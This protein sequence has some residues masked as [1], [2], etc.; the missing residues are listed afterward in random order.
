MKLPQFHPTHGYDDTAY[1]NLRSVFRN[2]IIAKPDSVLGHIEYGLDWLIQPI[3]EDLNVTGAMFGVQSKTVDREIKGDHIAL[4]LE[5]RTINYLLGIPLPVML[6]VCHRGTNIGYWIWLKEWEIKNPNSNWKQNETVTVHIPIASQLNDKTIKDIQA[7]VDQHQSK[8]NLLEMTELLSENDPDFRVIYSSDGMHTIVPK[9]NQ[10]RLVKILPSDAEAAERLQEGWETGKEV[11]FNGS[12]DFGG[13]LGT[14]LQD[15]V[16]DH[17]QIT[18]RPSIISEDQFFQ[19]E[20][21]D[22][23][24]NKAKFNVRM[25]YIQQGEKVVSI[26]GELVKELITVT[27]TFDSRFHHIGINFNIELSDDPIQALDQSNFLNII[28]KIKKITL[29]NLEDINRPIIL[30][31]DKSPLE[32]SSFIEDTQV[33]LIEALAT[34]KSKLRTPIVVPD[35]YNNRMLDIA[36]AI[37]EGLNTGISSR[38]L[39]FIYNGQPAKVKIWIQAP[40]DALELIRRSDGMIKLGVNGPADIEF[41]GQTLV[42]GTTQCVFYSKKFLNRH[43]VISKLEQ[44]DSK[45]GVEI[46]F[47]FEVDMQQSHVKFLEWPHDTDENIKINMDQ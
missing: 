40:T 19:I 21:L 32:F 41:L 5:V 38:M 31:G 39:G 46:E 27:F 18:L 13:L 36:E 29:I 44:A 24:E 43:E 35:K 33:H 17:G 7:Y 34:I 20:F 1:A 26:K 11:N 25:K 8:S 10:T 37:V 9:H 2:W 6:H 14:F 16:G 12:L 4:S 22:E 45:K 47:E 30:D 3:N 42:L 23:V 28:K 15:I